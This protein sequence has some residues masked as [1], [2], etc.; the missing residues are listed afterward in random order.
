[1]RAY[2]RKET[3]AMSDR[4]GDRDSMEGALEETKGD[5]KQAWGDMTDDDRMKAEGMMDE[6]KG[7]AQ[8]AMGDV[9]DAAADVK[10]DIERA[11]R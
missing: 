7:K 1:M 9:K 2:A 10:D 4:S 5:M 3:A 8:Q 11:T 6:M